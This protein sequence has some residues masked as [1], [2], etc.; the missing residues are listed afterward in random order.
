MATTTL[1]PA[2]IDE[3]TSK[4]CEKLLEQSTNTLD[5]LTSKMCEKMIELLPQAIVPL[6][7]ETLPTVLEENLPTLVSKIAEQ[8]QLSSSAKSNADVYINETKV[9]KFN[10]ENRI[11]RTK[12]EQFTRCTQLLSLYDECLQQNPP[13]IPRRFREDK[14]H[15]RNAREREIL[16]NRNMSNL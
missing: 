4:M 15:V 1:D 2:T 7:K 12:Y 13:Y 16:F 14:Y 8:Q 5:E 9:Y 3:I 6:M 10:K 11:R